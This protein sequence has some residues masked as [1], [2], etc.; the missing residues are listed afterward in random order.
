M[1]VREVDKI[2]GIGIPPTLLACVVSVDF[3]LSQATRSSKNPRQQIRMLDFENWFVD[4]NII[5][6]LL[7]SLLNGRVIVRE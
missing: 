4:G 7:V 3:P 6:S 1:L 5:G 2:W